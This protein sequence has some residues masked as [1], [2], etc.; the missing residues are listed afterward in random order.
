MTPAL[1]CENCKDYTIEVIGDKE[2]SCECEFE[3]KEDYDDRK[4]HEEKEQC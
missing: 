2:L 4:Y 1:Y 3:S